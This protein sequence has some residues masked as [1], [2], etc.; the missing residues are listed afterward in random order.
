MTKNERI[1]ELEIQVK[2]LAP[3]HIIACD[4]YHSHD[5]IGI[6]YSV[7]S[8]CCMIPCPGCEHQERVERVRKIVNG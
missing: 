3:K 5:R 2:A 7:D 6:T 8:R 1:T 4:E